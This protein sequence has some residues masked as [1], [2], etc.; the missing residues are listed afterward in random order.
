MEKHM[1][2]QRMRISRRP[3][4]MAVLLPVVFLSV[5]LSAQILHV[6]GARPSFEVATIKPSKLDETRSGMGFSAGGRGFTSTNATVRDMI[7]EAYNVKSANQIQGAS[8]WMTT[9][10]F[11]IEARM[12]DSEVA[13]LA[14]LSMEEK[15]RQVR[16]MLQS[17][18][19]E[20]CGLKLSEGSRESSFFLLLP[21]LGGPRL[22][23]TQMVPA[24]PSSNSPAH[25]AIGPRVLRKGPGKVE[26]T[27][28]SMGMLTDMISRQP[29]LGA[30]GGFT[31]GDLVVDKTGLSGM[32]DWALTWEPVVD[33][34]T[35]DAIGEA[36]GPSLFT[37]L[38]EQLGLR[39]Q[40]TKGQVEVLVI[41]HITRPS[42]D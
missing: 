12:D 1:S 18:L 16:L 29:E 35:R 28:V 11:D 39:L 33:D 31:V 6:T 5:R 20:R 9:E 30:D 26:A 22:K 42:G 13:L 41:D 37:A 8:G 4:L 40:R 2:D 23:P 34:Q 3:S 7:Q 15:I 38:Q 32:Y 24:G 21:A 10:K 27:G 25:P 17:L 14:T 19:E 36:A